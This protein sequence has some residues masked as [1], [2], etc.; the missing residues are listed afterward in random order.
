MNLYQLN[1]EML[2]GD[3]TDGG[4]GV[5]AD[6]QHLLEAATL[7]QVDTFRGFAT[8]CSPAGSFKSF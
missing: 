1:F 8:L 4:Y 2:H 5:V 7:L 3:L 6:E